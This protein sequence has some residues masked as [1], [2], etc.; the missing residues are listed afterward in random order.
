MNQDVGTWEGCRGYGEQGSGDPKPCTELVWRMPQGHGASE[1]VD[2][3]G[4]ANAA[5]LATVASGLG[6]EGPGRKC[7]SHR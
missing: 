6:S 5:T 1:M 7:G 3:P 2:G 4:P